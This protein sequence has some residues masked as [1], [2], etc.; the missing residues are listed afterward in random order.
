MSD[1]AAAI[2][3]ATENRERF[4]GELKEFLRIP[5]VSTLPQHQPDMQRAAEWV[6]AQL[7]GL[8]LENIAIMPT[9]G[10]PVV[11]GEWLRAGAAPTVLVYGHY[12]VQPTDP[13]NEWVSAPFDPTQ[14]G[15]NLYAR[16]ASDMK[17]QVHAFLK[18]LES[19]TH[20]G[21]LPVNLKI[22]V[23]GEEEI[24]SPNLGSFVKTHARLLK[25]DLVL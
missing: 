10:H 4:L 23:E 22:L 18:G 17:G 21:P 5:S 19:L 16:G 11:Y 3:F 8:G 7:A 14:R 20:A 12:D 9:G 6:A 1:S 25:C 13:L 2:K 24:G 15:D